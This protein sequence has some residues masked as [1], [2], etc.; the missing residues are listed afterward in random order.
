[1]LSNASQSDEKGRPPEGLFLHSLA[2]W[3]SLRRLLGR[4]IIGALWMCAVLGTIGAGGEVLLAGALQAFLVSVGALDA[5]VAPRIGSMTWTGGPLAS[6]ML[7][8]AVAVVRSALQFLGQHVNSYAAEA[9]AYRLRCLAYDELIHRTTDTPHT[10]SDFQFRNGE[11]VSKTVVTV[12]N[13][14]ALAGQ[15]AMATLLCAALVAVA[16]AQTAITLVLL[17]LLLGGSRLLGRVAR[18]VAARIAP[19]AT[20][21]N[22]DVERVARNRLYLKLMGLERLEQVNLSTRSL[23]YSQYVVR[24]AA[25]ASGVSA[26]TGAGALTV[27]VLVALGSASSGTGGAALLT[28]FYLLVRLGQAAQGVSSNVTVLQNLWPVFRHALEFAD[29][30]SDEQLARAHGAS[31]PVSFLGG[32]HPVVGMG[33]ARTSTGAAP[34]PPPRISIRGLHY[35]YPGGPAVLRGLDLEVAPGAHLGIVGPSGAGKTTLLMLLLGMLKPGAGEVRLDDLAAADWLTKHR[36]AVGYVGPD[37]MLI[38]GTVRS[39]LFYGLP[40]DLP[41][42]QLDAVAIDV[43]KQARLATFATPEGLNRI[44]TEEGEGLSAGQKQRL[45]FAR[46]LM[47]QP[48]LLILDEPTAN[49]DGETEAE[50]VQTIASLRA[51]C[52]VVIVTHRP[53]LLV[54]T[55]H[56]LDLGAS[57]G[58]RISSRSAGELAGEIP[59]RPVSGVAEPVRE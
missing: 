59:E 32:A 5:S 44:I 51:R 2:M 45:A 55:D 16:P 57:N 58:A 30:V 56:V 52:T 1:M 4:R 35:N 33:Q 31:G 48:A 29:S 6:S 3:N 15:V 24:A 39:N 42:E 40:M 9:A 36:F 12:L 18:G 17:A 54:T 19:A 8:L 49:L 14:A 25:A 26:L 28:F 41:P 27:V 38:A 46:A 34:V 50:L 47:R 43:L 20:Q 53:T 23:T 13:T 22:R 7:L 11:L 37:P 21:I 10:N